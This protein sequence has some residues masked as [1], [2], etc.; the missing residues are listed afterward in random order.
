MFKTIEC[1]KCGTKNYYDPGTFTTESVEIIC[2]KCRYPNRC[3]VRNGNL[4]HENT[5]IGQAVAEYAGEP[6]AVE[7]DDRQS[8]ALKRIRFGLRMKMMLLFLVVPGLIIAGSGY[9]SQLRL[10]Q[11]GVSLTQDCRQIVQD[12]AEKN[13][14]DISSAVALQAKLYLDSHVGLARE[15]FSNDR[16]FNSIVLQQVAVTGYTDIYAE[17]DQDGAWRLWIHPNPKLVGA[18]MRSVIEPLLGKH[19]PETWRIVVGVKEGPTRRVSHGYYKWPDKDGVVRD[20][21]MVNTPVQGYPYFISCTAYMDE[22]TK[23]IALL[24]QSAKSIIAAS[25]KLHIAI[26]TATLAIIGLLV[27]AFS[28]WY[29]IRPVAMLERRATEISLGKNLDHSIVAMSEDEIGS[30]A[31]AIERL[32]ISVALMLRRF[33]KKEER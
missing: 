8:P 4:S 18:D 16:I 26:L 32:R 25:K 13:M 3:V 19:F 2:L 9:I 31:R 24:E 5:R 27:T 29:I 14:I 30:L 17:P 20:K 33:S 23:P 7:E 10:Q 1:R 6:I 12:L 11:M 28:N 21:F 15:D 22:F